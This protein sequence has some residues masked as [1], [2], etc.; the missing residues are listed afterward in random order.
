MRC[1]AWVMLLAAGSL[2]AQPS[3]RITSPADGT[4]VHPG[5]AVNVTVEVSGA[6]LGGLVMV[7]GDLGSSQEVRDAPPYR[8]TVQVKKDK[9]PAE[10]FLT[11]VGATSPGHL[12]NSNIVSVFVKRPDLPTSITVYPVAALDFMLG[13]KRYI[14]V[15]GNY[16][17]GTTA[18][19]T[20]SSQTTYISDNPRVAT[21]QAQGIVPP[22]APGNARV[23]VTYRNLLK[24][25]VPLRVRNR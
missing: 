25:E 5:D 8:F 22:F 18:D 24:A 6:S 7:L 15:T 1:A 16:A 9:G 20:Q 14:N 4:T 13:Q 3:L 10:Y 12:V 11:T 19:L 21:V 23:I 17:D 2:C